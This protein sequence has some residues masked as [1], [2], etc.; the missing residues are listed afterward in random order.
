MALPVRHPGGYA[1]KPI[2][3][4]ALVRP[5]M[6]FVGWERK[7]K[8]SKNETPFITDVEELRSRARKSINNGAITPADV[9]TPL[10]P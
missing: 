3:Y 10:P 2:K 6:L 7:M 5:F 4:P 1:Q 8:V 9:A